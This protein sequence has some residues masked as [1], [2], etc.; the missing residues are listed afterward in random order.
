MMSVPAIDDLLPRVRQGG[1]LILVDDERR[2]NEG[3][4]FIAAEKATADAI[5][6]MALHARGLISLA[7]TEDRMRQ[8]GLALITDDTG[9]QTKFG[10][11]F[12]TPIDAREGVASGMSAHDR[13]R[14][15]SVA[16]AD[17]AK[18]TDLIL[19]LIHI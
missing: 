10:T 15:I 6:F 2:E 7:L 8:L 1:M 13:A 11:A 19:S 4:L 14:T 5:N 12:A 17:N 16:I 9:N 3:D 18:P